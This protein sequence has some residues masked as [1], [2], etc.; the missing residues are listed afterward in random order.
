[1]AKYVHFYYHFIDRPIEQRNPEDCGWTVVTL[2]GVTIHNFD[3]TIIEWINDNVS[4]KW[5]WWEFDE[6]T[7][8]GISIGFE[9]KEDA[10]AFKLKWL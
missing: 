10:M 2:D 6:Y 8:G 7:D 1:M 3:I 4:G 5:T 9:N